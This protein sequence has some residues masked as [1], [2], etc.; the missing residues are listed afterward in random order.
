MC[1]SIQI[2]NKYESIKMY[3]QLCLRNEKQVR[4]IIDPNRAEID[5]IN[6]WNINQ[7]PTGHVSVEAKLK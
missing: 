7:P 2:C 4:Y 3:L 1:A 6:D 5:V